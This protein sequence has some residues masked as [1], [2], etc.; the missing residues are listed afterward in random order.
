MVSGNHALIRIEI[1]R[2]QLDKKV[3]ILVEVAAGAT[4]EHAILQ[5][6]IQKRFPDINLNTAKIRVSG[7]LSKPSAKMA[8][9]ATVQKSIV[10]FW[11]ITKVTRKKRAA[12]G[13]QIRKGSGDL[14]PND[15]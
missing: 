13:K 12:E 15:G 1:T 5:S 4:M 8:R 2:A 6:C 11:L 3:S 14:A 7:K 9:P 10:F